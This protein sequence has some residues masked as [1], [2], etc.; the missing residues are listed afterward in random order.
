MDWVLTQVFLRQIRR[1]GRSENEHAGHAGPVG[2]VRKHMLLLP[3]ISLV[4]LTDLGQGRRIGVGLKGF[5]PCPWT[6][7]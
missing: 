3:V 7:V 5:F 6:E 2:C 1:W 4:K